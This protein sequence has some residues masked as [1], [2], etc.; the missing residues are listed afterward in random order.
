M[1]IE[2]IRSLNR[3]KDIFEVIDN[4]FSVYG[5]VLDKYDSNEVLRYA[6]NH[7]EIP[8]EGNNYISSLKEYKKFTVIKKIENEVFGRL[9]VQAGI[10]TGQNSSLTGFEYHQGS[11]VIIAVTDC[12]LILGK[13]WDMK[14]N[15][16]DVNKAELFYIKKGQIIELYGTTLHYTPCKVNK[17]GYITV[18]L[19]LQGTNSIIDKSEEALLTKKNKFFICHKSQQEKIKQGIVPGLLGKILD[20]KFS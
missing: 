14:N 9:D 20:L 18:V 3:D 6:L 19:L 10:C 17:E 12:V 4:K 11:E 7:V 13:L 8:V 2:K 5:R 16:Y 1:S 15:E